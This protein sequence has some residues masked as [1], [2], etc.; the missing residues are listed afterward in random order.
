MYKMYQA[1]LLGS[2]DAPVSGGSAGETLGDRLGVVNEDG[3]RTTF[4]DTYGKLIAGEELSKSDLDVIRKVEMNISGNA[5]GRMGQLITD[6]GLDG[7]WSYN[8][9]ADPGFVENKVQGPEKEE[10]KQLQLHLRRVMLY[11]SYLLMTNGWRRKRK[12][13]MREAGALGDWVKVAY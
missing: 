5:E 8:T 1:H 11:L 10:L 2:A 9:N 3:S 6:V 7:K 4:Q 12:A 13:L